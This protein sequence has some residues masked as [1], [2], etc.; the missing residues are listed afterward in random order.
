[1]SYKG[2]IA[3]TGTSEAIRLDKNLFRQHA[4]FK[5]QAEVRADVIGPGKLLVSIVDA[6]EIG[7]EDDPLVGACLSFLEMDMGRKPAGISAVDANDIA[8]GKE[9]TAGVTVTDEELA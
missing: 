6:S 2:E 7:T 9:L 3:K 1:M 8:R 4:E 5:Q